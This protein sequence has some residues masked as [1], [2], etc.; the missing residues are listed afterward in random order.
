[1][2]SILRPR[3]EWTPELNITG[4]APSELATGL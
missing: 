4:W 3:L 1:M 2:N